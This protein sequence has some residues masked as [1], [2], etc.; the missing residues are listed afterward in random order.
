MRNAK[1][2]PDVQP[3]GLR[4]TLLGITLSRYDTFSSSTIDTVERVA[5]M[6]PER[7]AERRLLQFEARPQLWDLSRDPLEY[8]LGVLVAA[9]VA[10]EVESGAGAF[11]PDD[12]GTNE[13]DWLGEYIRPTAQSGQRY[14]VA[15]FF[16]ESPRGRAKIDTLLARL[17]TLGFRYANHQDVHDADNKGTVGEYGNPQD[18]AIV[19]MGDLL[20]WV[21]AHR[22]GRDAPQKKPLV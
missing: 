6:L 9:S 4:T 20:A 2:T 7:S 11:L 22:T 14:V 1:Q 16:A 10:R 15:Q 18:F 21:Y 19:G 8:Q 17:G 13:A 5:E 3:D 12:P